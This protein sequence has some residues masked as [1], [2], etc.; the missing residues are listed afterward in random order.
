MLVL[1]H[2]FDHLAFL[3]F[4]GL[5][6]RCGTDQVPLAVLAAPLDHLHDGVVTHAGLPAGTPVRNQDI[7][8]IQLRQENSLVFSIFLIFS[9]LLTP[10]ATLCRRSAALAVL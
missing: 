5:G 8:A 4:Q 3:D 7:I 9:H 1:H 6:E 2:P 10:W